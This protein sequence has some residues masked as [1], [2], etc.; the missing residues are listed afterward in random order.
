MGQER[1]EGM[2][3]G[4]KKERKKETISRRREGGGGKRKHTLKKMGAMAET[5]E[6][7]G[8]SRDLFLYLLG[9][10]EE[11]GPGENSLYSKDTSLLFSLLFQVLRLFLFSLI[12]IQTLSNLHTYIHSYSCL[13]EKS[14]HECQEPSQPKS[15]IGPCRYDNALKWPSE[16]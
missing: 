5:G 14:A 8:K 4:R 1:K 13:S 7:R 9:E 12:Y 3:E 6:N 10:R 2:K 15:G 16:T 11:Q